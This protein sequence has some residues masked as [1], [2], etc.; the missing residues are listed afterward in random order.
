MLVLTGKQFR[1]LDEYTIE[2]EP[3][4]SLGLMERA[5]RAFAQAIERR[6]KSPRNVFVFSG[7]GNNG[8][9]GLAI[10][11]LLSIRGYSVSAWLFNTKG[12][13]SPDCQANR[14]LLDSVPGLNFTEVSQGFD[15]P[16]I[17]EGDITVD[18]LFGTGLT[19]PLTGGFSQLVKKINAASGTVISID[20]PSG[21]MAEDN[22]TNDY[23][24]VVRASLTLTV[25]LPKLAFLLADNAECVGEWEAVDIGLSA[26]GLRQMHSPY[27]IMEQRELSRLLHQRPAF[28]H[29]GDMGQA[30]L[31]AGAKGMAGAAILA[32]RACLRSGI[33][34]LSLHT[35][36]ANFQVLQGAVPEAVLLPEVETECISD[37]HDTSKFNAVGIGPGLGKADVTAKALRLY[38]SRSR[39]PMVID[40]DALNLIAQHTDLLHLIP[41]GSILT[42]HPKEL[43]RIV[44]TCS[45]SYERLKRAVE[46]ARR[47]GVTVVLKGHYTAVCKADGGVEFCPAGNAGMATAG[48]GDVLTGIVT[49]LLAQGYSPEQA[50]SLGVWLHATA[51][52]AAAQQLGEECLIAS[53]ITA[54][55]PDAF[56]KLKASNTL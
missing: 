43:E 37:C 14:E 45:S 50:A 36:D 6:Y 39:R 25:Q 19:R 26:E 31:V 12:E 38:L 4:S 27:N 48:S 21:L 49:S 11:R 28:A 40:A 22:S 29:K 41:K 1:E 32:S 13:L 34:K 53:D 24:S 18:A 33:G 3:V 23:T 55:L 52:D 54:H 44:G 35:A 46:L 9:D 47:K 7:P 20:L 2:H 16:E 56:A 5:A 15:F 8:G 42:P 51:G 10:A 17:R 30:L